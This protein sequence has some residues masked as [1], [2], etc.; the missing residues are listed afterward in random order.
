MPT[1]KKAIVSHE[2]ELLKQRFRVGPLRD[3]FEEVQNGTVSDNLKL[4]AAEIAW[5]RIVDIARSAP[6][7]VALPASQYILDR[8]YGKAAPRAEGDEDGRAFTVVIK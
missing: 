6:P 8:A 3:L 1:P 7:S 5:V 2:Q 4:T